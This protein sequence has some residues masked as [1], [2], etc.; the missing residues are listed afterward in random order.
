MISV[1]K[2]PNSSDY[3]IPLPDSR[4]IAERL[5]LNEATCVTFPDS[6]PTYTLT[7]SNKMSDNNCWETSTNANKLNS[8][9][10]IDDRLISLD[11]PTT[12]QP[13]H[14]FCNS[15]IQTLSSNNNNNKPNAITLD[16]SALQQGCTNVKMN[17]N[18]K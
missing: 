1:Y 10:S 7:N 14:A 13:P 11:T 17:D 9:D 6:L 5:W 4:A 15:P 2:F 12:I 16:P 3:L 8:S 18:C